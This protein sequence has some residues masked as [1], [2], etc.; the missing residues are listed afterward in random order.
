LS[1]L[2]RLLAERDPFRRTKLIKLHLRKKCPRIFSGKKWAFSRENDLRETG[3][4][5]HALPNICRVRHAQEE[6]EEEEEEEHQSAA[7]H[8]DYGT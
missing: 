2:G 7:I 3:T 8:T 6:E 4:T 1:G 5:T